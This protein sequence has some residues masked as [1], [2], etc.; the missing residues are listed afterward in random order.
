MICKQFTPGPSIVHQGCLR[1]YTVFSN[2]VL[3]LEKDYD[4][5]WRCG[6]LM[7]LKLFAI[8]G[9]TLKAFGSYTTERPFHY[10]LNCTLH[11]PSAEKL[12]ASSQGFELNVVY[13][14]VE[15][16]LKGF[17]HHFRFSLC[18]RRTTIQEIL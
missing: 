3:D 12:R 8:S 1:Q 18:K 5:Y 11:G 13:W 6:T 14:L 2:H 10:S 4:S 16:A 7:E 15:F 9:S 17:P